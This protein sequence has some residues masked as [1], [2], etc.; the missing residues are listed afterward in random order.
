MKCGNS[1]NARHNQFKQEEPKS[2]SI[3]AILAASPTHQLKLG[4]G[5]RK[6]DVKLVL[7]MSLRHGR[8][9]G[10]N[11]PKSNHRHPK[12]LCSECRKVKMRRAVSR[13][14][15][16]PSSF[17]TQHFSNFSLSVEHH[18]LPLLRGMRYIRVGSTRL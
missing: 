8:A 16:H 18:V 13:E 7:A 12:W 10:A 15:R 1:Q 2:I 11:K 17:Q 6:V 9:I 5:V 14:D 4:S 3:L